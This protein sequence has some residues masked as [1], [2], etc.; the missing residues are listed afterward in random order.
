MAPRHRARAGRAGMRLPLIPLFQMVA[1]AQSGQDLAAGT[2]APRHGCPE[3]TGAMLALHRRHRG[4][5]VTGA[6]VGMGTRARAGP[7]FTLF[8]FFPGIFAST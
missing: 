8:P 1:Q 5:A 3:G 6:E 4:M 7:S 2:T